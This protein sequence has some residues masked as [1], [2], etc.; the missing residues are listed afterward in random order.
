MLVSGED[1]SM[2][3]KILNCRW[4][5]LIIEVSDVS[6]ESE[7]SP[8]TKHFRY[9]PFYFFWMSKDKG[10]G[11]VF[12]LKLVNRVRQVGLPRSCLNA[13]PWKIQVVLKRP[14]WPVDLRSV[15]IWKH[16]QDSS[17]F[18]VH[19]NRKKGGEKIVSGFRDIYTLGGGL[20][21]KPWN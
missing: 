7:D 6:V 5:H 19:L 15:S 3:W 9:L 18:L 17:S 2:F 10:K 12:F 4:V 1:N 16:G 21:R 8:K 13:S 11:Y 20:E 14:R